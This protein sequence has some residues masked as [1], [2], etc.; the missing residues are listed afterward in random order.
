MG[1]EAL[2]ALLAGGDPGAYLD[3]DSDLP[4]LPAARFL[5]ARGDGPPAG[6]GG[7]GP[8]GEAS[9]GGREEGRGAR[10][11]EGFPTPEVL[12]LSSSLSSE[13]TPGGG[14][15]GG[16]AS[17]GGVLCL[18]SDEEEEEHRGA[19]ARRA[20]RRGGAPAAAARI[21]EH[22]ARV[23]A[24]A[25]DG[26]A[27]EGFEWVGAGRRSPMMER[28]GPGGSGGGSRAGPAPPPP[29]RSPPESFPWLVRLP[30]FRPVEV[31][32]LQAFDPEAP[33]VH[34]DYRRQFQS[35]GTAR[36]AGKDPRGHSSSRGASKQSGWRETKEGEKF[37]VNSSGKQVRM[38]KARTGEGL[39]GSLKNG[40][41]GAR[42][43]RKGGKR[44]ARKGGGR[45][46]RKP[47][48]RT[49]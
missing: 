40:G 12:E 48:A 39:K 11:V 38:G 9:G 19:E 25:G 24:D 26:G 13:W 10:R 36:V 44:K 8:G 43:K 29:R 46:R 34:V 4:P 14:D 20:K 2:A 47:Q 33:P 18:S 23:L 28:D 22:R 32:K 49:R 27:A 6:G 21:A 3:D 16:P 1:G 7:A 31:L 35:P 17:A 30:H 42:G 5:Q 41:A 37:F 15:E 45:P